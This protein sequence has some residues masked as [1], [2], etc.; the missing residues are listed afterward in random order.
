MGEKNALRSRESTRPI[1]NRMATSTSP[2]TSWVAKGTKIGG[3]KSVIVANER[4]SAIGVIW[5]REH[6]IPF[7]SCLVYTWASR[8]ISKFWLRA[9]RPTA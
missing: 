1:L 3:Q 5:H 9:L 8:A 6:D 2:K 7:S 4:I